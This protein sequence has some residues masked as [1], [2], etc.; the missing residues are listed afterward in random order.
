[1]KS[2]RASVILAAL[3]VQMSFLAP[4]RAGQFFVER[5]WYVSL[6]NGSGSTQVNVGASAKY[7]G[8]VDD[9]GND[10]GFWTELDVLGTTYRGRTYSQNHL[11]FQYSENMKITVD[12]NSYGASGAIL[13]CTPAGDGTH[14]LGYGIVEIL[15]SAWGV[16]NERNQKPGTWG[17]TE[18]D[19]PPE[20]EPD[21][22]NGPDGGSDPAPGDGTEDGGYDNT[23]I[24][25][26]LDRGNFKLTDLAGGVRFDLNRDGIAEA[27]SW[28]EP[29]SG[30]GWLALDRNGNGAI[31]DGG[32]LFGNFT[33]QPPSDTPH[34]YLALQVFDEDDDGLISPTDSVYPDFLLWVDGDHDGMSSP[35]E[36]IGLAN[37]GVE[38]ISLG[39]VE[40]RSS[41][42][43]GNEF[44][45][46]SHVRTRRGMTKS[47]DVFLLT[48]P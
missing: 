22:G 24:L 44:R 28:T 40:S 45:Y 21:L 5:V 6:D 29:G 4:A 48:A 11:T 18:C 13:N 31:D 33:D 38:W 15:H 30:D 47:V 36:L 1:M 25:I 34:G 42:R 10:W 7:V 9:Q 27:L 35:A 32:E 26:D 20:E 46:K 3:I 43:H 39:Y 37:A 2:R 19:D 41:D 12:A 14:Y 23:P 16:S 8:A 17:L